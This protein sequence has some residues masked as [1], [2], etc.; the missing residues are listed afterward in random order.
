MGMRGGGS[1]STD[2][3]SVISSRSAMMGGRRRGE[4]SYTRALGVPGAPR[5]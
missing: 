2:G 3:V 1:S 5:E 4:M